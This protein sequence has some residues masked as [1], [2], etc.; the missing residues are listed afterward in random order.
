M[1][2]N[3]IRVCLPWNT[4]N[5]SGVNAFCPL[6][7]FIL[8]NSTCEYVTLNEN[9]FRECLVKND[10]KN[11]LDRHI[12]SISAQLSDS[13]N[14]DFWK[15]FEI[16]ETIIDELS[17][18]DFK[19]VHSYLLTCG[20]KPHVFYLKDFET[21]FYP[22]KFENASKKYFQM[23]LEKTECFA[24]ISPMLH[25]LERIK[26]FFNSDVINKK[27]HYSPLGVVCAD[28]PPIIKK[29]DRARRFL[30]SAE[31]QDSVTFFSFI[32]RW[33][34]QYPQDYYVFLMD[35]PD[36]EVYTDIINY[37]NVIF[38]GKNNISYDE[39]DNLFK[40]SDYFFSA[41]QQC[42]FYFL[43]RSMGSGV[44]P[45]VADLIEGFDDENAV[46]FKDIN[47]LIDKFNQLRQ[48]PELEETISNN[49]FNYVRTYFDPC[50]A[51]K[52]LE[53]IMLDGYFAYKQETTSTHS[54]TQF[55]FKGES[56]FGSLNYFLPKPR[57]VRKTDFEKSPILFD[58]L[59]I[60][61]ARIVSDGCNYVCV[62]K[63]SLYAAE[64]L[65]Y[66]GWRNIHGLYDLKSGN[67]SFEN[68]LT[69]MF[70]V[71]KL[72]YSIN[73]FPIIGRVITLFYT[74]IYRTKLVVRKMKSTF[75]RHF[76]GQIV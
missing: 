57:F 65:S 47:T 53:Q 50:V 25:T 71:V 10:V 55:I 69:K 35:E 27:L 41:T 56:R 70:Y 29:P 19:I 3:P 42:D 59:S 76:L 5:Y 22:W 43:L 48:Q 13:I 63:Y 62:N 49:A 2:N 46:I 26:N 16:A 17:E 23:M 45:I 7:R 36:R 14:H 51:A 15:H 67:L 33:K 44:I 21:L 73:L 34:K 18:Y 61:S 38:I 74:P 52:K 72:L 37:P 8:Q 11:A 58:V 32:E 31:S 40:I 66:L 30:F 12:L 54:A 39:Y 75:K 24:I 60:G 6:Y 28:H 9:L 68:A 64:D 1:S 4:K 20:L